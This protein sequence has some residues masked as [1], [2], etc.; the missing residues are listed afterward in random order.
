MDAIYRTTRDQLR[1]SI[2]DGY[3]YLG[4]HAVHRK[5]LAPAEVALAAEVVELCDSAE[6]RSVVEL[7][8]RLDSPG[9]ILAALEAKRNPPPKPKRRPRRGQIIGSHYDHNLGLIV[10][11]RA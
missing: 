1:A 4:F 3:L 2:E 7:A 6:F 8:R 9:E 11:D 10:V 5:P